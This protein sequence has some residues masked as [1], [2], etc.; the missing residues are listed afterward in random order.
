MS[1]KSIIAK[2]KLKYKVD[3]TN[4]TPFARLLYLKD[5]NDEFVELQ[6]E[7]E[8]FNKTFFSS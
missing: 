4:S 6:S 1:I 8:E 7:Y 2:L 3:E 5:V